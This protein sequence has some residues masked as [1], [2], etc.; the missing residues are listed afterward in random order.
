MMNWSQ[1]LCLIRSNVLNGAPDRG[2][3]QSE[4]D[5]RNQFQR[6]YDRTLFSSPVRRLQDKAQVFPLEPHD[7]VRTRLTHSLEVANIAQGLTRL[8]LGALPEEFRPSEAQIDQLTIIAATCG[9]IHD[10]GN[11]PFG[12]AGEEAMIEWFKEKLKSNPALHKDLQLAGRDLSQDFERFDGNPQTLRLVTRLTML[13]DYDGLSLTTGTLSAS[14]KY[15]APSD[16]TNEA[17]HGRGKPGFFFSEEALVRRIQQETGT[18]DAR[19]P[20]TFLVEAADDIVYSAVDLEDGVKKSSLTWS[21]LR[22]EF[23]KHGVNPDTEEVFSNAE[24]NLQNRL[25]NSKMTLSEQEKDE[26]L[27]QLFRTMLVWKHMQAVSTTF[28]KNITAIMAGT[29]TSELLKEGSTAQL[30]K[31]SKKIARE[32]VFPSPSIL[33][34]ELM[35]RKVIHDLMDLF[36]KGI[37]QAPYNKPSDR[38]GLHYKAYMLLSKN[39]RKVFEN[40][41]EQDKAESTGIPVT[42]RRLQLVADYICGMTDTFAVTLHKE[43]FNG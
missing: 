32:R 11:P 20:I 24:K 27:S 8:A 30:W 22:S 33:R 4:L 6:D 35:G 26:P 14:L 18:E 40:A 7:S 13:G 31:A 19:N 12:H 10:L 28:G 41:V 36:W 43:L 21:E 16:Q 25:D 3:T 42:Y 37:E 2:T 9:L 1:L 23:N 34:L 39:Y 17:D 38:K 5:K 29:F 15:I